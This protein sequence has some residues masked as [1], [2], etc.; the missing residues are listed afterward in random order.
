MAYYY[1]NGRR[2]SIG[3]AGAPLALVTIWF[4]LWILIG[5]ALGDWSSTLYIAVLPYYVMIKIIMFLGFQGMAILILIGLAI[6]IG[7]PFFKRYK[8][9]K[10]RSE[11]RRV[12]KEYRTVT[13][14]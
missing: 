13:S 7:Y 11:E 4:V 6:L 10:V 3:L 8:N 12:G 14:Q 9:Q 5:F 1:R 2:V